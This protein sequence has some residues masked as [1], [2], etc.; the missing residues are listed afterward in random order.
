MQSI[1]RGFLLRRKLIL[2]KINPI[3]T[4][5]DDNEQNMINNNINNIDIISQSTIQGKKGNNNLE[6]TT[7]IMNFNPSVSRSMEYNNE[8]ITD[9][10]YLT[11]NLVSIYKLFILLNIKF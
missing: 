3:L 2:S 4:F 5:C 6:R 8:K 1:V 9:N 10:K 11:V 7:S